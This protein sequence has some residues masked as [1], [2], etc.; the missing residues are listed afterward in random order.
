[1]AEDDNKAKDLEDAKKLDDE[2]GGKDELKVDKEH[3]RNLKEI[4]Q[5]KTQT[6]E[7][8]A[9]LKAREEDADRSRLSKLK[10]QQKFQELAEEFR[11]KAEAAEQESKT[12]KQSVVTDKKFSAIKEAALKAGIRKEALDDLELLDFDGVEIEA[13]TMGNWSV[14]GADQF[15]ERAKV[16]RPHWFGKK[17]TRI[18]SSDP[19]VGAAGK[20]TFK[21]V[22]K[23]EK[24]AEETGDF[25]PLNALTRRYQQQQ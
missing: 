12:L 4:M 14:H 18:N 15:I 5:L 20:V 17:G 19:E 21:D 24:V 1:M 23:A 13:T 11:Q 25:A 22:M 10:E 3:E 2:S 6:K 9:K 7:L 16:T 8:E